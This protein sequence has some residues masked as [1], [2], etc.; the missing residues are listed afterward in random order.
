MKW[1]YR[2]SVWEQRDYNGPLAGQQASQG[3]KWQPSVCARSIWMTLYK[4]FL[5]KVYFASTI[6]TMVRCGLPEPLIY[7]FICNLR[8]FSQKVK[9]LV[10]TKV[11]KSW[12]QLAFHPNYKGNQFSYTQVPL[13]KMPAF[14]TYVID[15]F[16][17]CRFRI[18]CALQ[19]L[20]KTLYQ[21]MELNYC[22][23]TVKSC[24]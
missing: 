12:L 7:V 19:H 21:L 10:N 13:G 20:L 5:G 24:H 14:V 23:F 15:S 17:R 22:T 1:N 6:L 18:L 8:V 4:H 9:W 11:N 3:R 2:V 16:A